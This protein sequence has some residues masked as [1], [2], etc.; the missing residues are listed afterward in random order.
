MSAVRQSQDSIGEPQ[1]EES[2]EYVRVPAVID[3]YGDKIVTLIDEHGRPQTRL[4][5]E[6]YLTR[7]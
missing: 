3:S 4:I 6:L 2:G 1:P 5:A 7:P